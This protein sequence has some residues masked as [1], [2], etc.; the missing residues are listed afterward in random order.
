MYKFLL[1]F[2]GTC[3][4]KSVMEQVEKAI[5]K[6]VAGLSTVGVQPVGMVWGGTEIT[7]AESRALRSPAP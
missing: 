2:T 3:P 1:G 6:A 4:D 7:D 5:E